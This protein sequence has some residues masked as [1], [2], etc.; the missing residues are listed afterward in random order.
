MRMGRSDG[1]EVGTDMFGEYPTEYSK[2]DLDF[3]N[4]HLF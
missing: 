2:R 4:K 1:N 3:S